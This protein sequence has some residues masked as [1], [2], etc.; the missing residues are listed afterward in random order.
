MAY[1]SHHHNKKSGATYVYSVQS[2]WDKEKKV[3]RNKQVCLGK[4][5]PETG[6]IIPSKRQKKLTERVE[7]ASGVTAT[8]QI[9]G[10]SLILDHLAR[11][12]GLAALIKRCFPASHAEI[13]SLVYFIV[14]KGLPL[15][16]CEFWS[17]GHLHPMGAT[18]RSQKVS[19]LLFSITEEERQRFLSLWLEKITERDY[20]CYDI[21][22]VSSYSTRNECVEYGYNRDAESLP[23]INLAML[24]GQKSRLPA[25]YRR[26]QGNIS[27]VATLATSL[28]AMD[29]IGAHKMHLVMDRGFFSIANIDELL[30]R[31]HHF[32]IAVPTGRKWVEEIIDQHYDSIA[33]P[34]N[35][36][37][38]G[39]KES[40]Y[41]ATT[42]H[43]WGHDNRRTYLHVYHNAYIAAEAFDDFTNRLVR[44]K[45]ELEAGGKT[46]ESK[47][48]CARFFVIR[49][50][51]KRGKRVSFNDAEIQKHRKRYAGFFC[52]L[53]TEIRDAEEAL[54]VYRAKDVVENCF[55]DLKNQMDMKR[56]RVHSSAAMDG[57][58]FVQFLAL[59]LI[60]RLREVLHA[61][62]ELRN[63]TVRETMEAMESF[64]KIT[65][66]GRY[67]KLYTEASPLQRKIMSAFG[68]IPQA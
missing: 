65:Y 59:I 22:S 68:G 64:A 66:S 11:E 14:Q 67:G 25:Y 32:T 8:M 29:F 21:T 43:K 44:C 50:T 7:A 16:R 36:I 27:D 60:S 39:D 52:I 41:A 55:D 2:Y 3:A 51:P 54:R 15:S 42:L 6:E 56:L 26:I 61:N 47:E 45:K 53:S 12:T 40:I 49:E 38:L 62:E 63:L 5:D 9:A 13:M 57:R 4:L 33:S 30:R 19:E 34:Q 46:T 37:Q 18:L 28:K 23:Q 17:T 24:F 31:R 20:L 10:P 58:I 48:F 35:Y 1:L